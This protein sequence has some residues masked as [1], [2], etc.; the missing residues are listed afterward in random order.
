MNYIELHLSVGRRRR[1]DVNIEEWTSRSVS[2]FLPLF[3]KWITIFVCNCCFLYVFV[4]QFRPDMNVR[5]E[6]DDVNE[7]RVSLKKKKKSQCQILLWYMWKSLLRDTSLHHAHT[8]P[9]S[10]SKRPSVSSAVVVSQQPFSPVTLQRHRFQINTPVSHFFPS[11]QFIAHSCRSYMLSCQFVQPVNVPLVD[12]TFPFW[13]N[14]F[15]C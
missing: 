3:A 2:G 6:S 12:I 10:H 1:W 15:T 7:F 9:S 4:T 8:T 13:E 11:F 14:W 5:S